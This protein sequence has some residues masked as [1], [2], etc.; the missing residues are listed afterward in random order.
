M[1]LHPTLLLFLLLA[2]ATTG[3]AQELRATVTVNAPQLTI[4]DRSVI[5]EFEN[6]V[7]DFLNAT[8]FTEERYE[9]E[10]RIECNFT[11]TLVREVNERLF[12][13]DLLI[14]SSRPVFGSDYNTTLI[15][16][17]DKN[18]TI[19]YEQ[20][21]PLDYSD[22]GFTNSL[23]SLLSFYAFVIIG[24]DK[25]TFAPMAGEEFYRGAELIVQ[26]LPDNVR[27]LDPGWTTNRQR[28]R[29]NL[30]REFLNPRART[31]RQLMYDYHRRGL[32]VMTTDPIAGRTVMSRSLT[33]LEKVRS[34][35]PNSLLLSIFSSS[36]TEELLSVFAP[37][38]QPERQ[39]VYAVMTSIDPINVTKLRAIR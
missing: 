11:F 20:Y 22:Q 36:K 13:V 10:E 9:E 32:D 33:N 21:Q 25:D 6:V 27:G 15:N 18:T 31:Y 3:V 38:P 4:I 1:R 8:Q 12:E 19:E 7:R 26:T 39:S 17:A 23:V 24:N 28:S 29:F 34:D 35:I 16:F 30:L 14:Q 37:A 2:S 5:E